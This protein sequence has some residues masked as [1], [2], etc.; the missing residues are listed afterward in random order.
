[1]CVCAS[2]SI[3]YVFHTSGNGNSH[4]LWFA[5]SQ[6]QW[7]YKFYDFLQLESVV[8]SS[9][10]PG[11]KNGFKPYIMNHYQLCCGHGWKRS[12][13]Y[14]LYIYVNTVY[15][16]IFHSWN[17]CPFLSKSI[18]THKKLQRQ[19]TEIVPLIRSKICDV[20]VRVSKVSAVGVKPRACSSKQRDDREIHKKPWSLEWEQ[21]WTTYVMNFPASHVWFPA[22]N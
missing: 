9:W 4:F 16:H 15:L 13:I 2:N 3:L 22:A 21:Q 7:I 19:V 20:L 12:Y 17:S 14:I 5:N 10:V 1:M 6:P 11:F 18:L 8:A